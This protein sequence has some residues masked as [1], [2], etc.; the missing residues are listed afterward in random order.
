MQRILLQ[1]N[2]LHQSKDE[3]LGRT[4]RLD[5]GYPNDVQGNAYDEFGFEKK[6][7][8][9]IALPLFVPFDQIVVSDAALERIKQSKKPLTEKKNDLINAILQ[10]KT[11]EHYVF[12]D[13]NTVLCREQITKILDDKKKDSS[14]ENVQ[15]ED[16]KAPNLNDLK[17]YVLRQ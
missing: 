1:Q 11:L 8:R 4:I 6:E 10:Q 9:R 17:Q 16:L 3:E 13:L 5:K 7:P 14:K 15:I 2:L 12:N